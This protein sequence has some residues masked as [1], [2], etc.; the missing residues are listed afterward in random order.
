MTWWVTQPREASLAQLKSENF[1]FVLNWLDSISASLFVD[2]LSLSNQKQI[3]ITIWWWDEQACLELTI[4]ATG[5]TQ[6]Q[7]AESTPKNAAKTMWWR[8]DNL[9]S[10]QILQRQSCE[11]TSLRSKHKWYNDR[12]PDWHNCGQFRQ[13]VILWEASRSKMLK[14]SIY[15]HCARLWALCIWLRS[16][17]KGAPFQE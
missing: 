2:W 1:A 13:V 9:H 7:N 5:F 6:F 11:S 4:D 8:K 17:C 12:I 14:S 15:Y 16:R 3:Q 10:P